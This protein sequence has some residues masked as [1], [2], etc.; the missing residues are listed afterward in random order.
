MYLTY[1]IILDILKNVI[2]LKFKGY[3]LFNPKSFI[4]FNCSIVFF[5]FIF[6]IG[7]SQSIL[8]S[9]FVSVYSFIH[10]FPCHLLFFG[11]FSFFYLLDWNDT[12]I[13]YPYPSYLGLLLGSFLNTFLD[14]VY[15]IMSAENVDIRFKRN[16]IHIRENL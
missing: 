4:L 9:F 8:L 5:L 3:R 6:G 7:L 13:Q 10:H 16:E 15:T 2:L 11:I 12:R 14:L 1:A